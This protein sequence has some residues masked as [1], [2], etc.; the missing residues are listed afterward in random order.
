M[1]R[2]YDRLETALALLFLSATVVAVLVAAIGRSIGL[3]LT[4]APQFAQLFLLWTCMFGADLCMRHGEHIRVTA[5]P[6]LVPEKA[7]RLLSLFSTVLIL[8]F[9]VWIAWHGFHLAIGNWSRELGG[10]GLSYGIVTLA[11]PVG[12][13]LLT[14][15]TL[16]RLWSRGWGG[17]LEPDNH[18]EEYPL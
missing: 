14:I 9:L 18:A 5:L 16:R 2:L 13:V 15:S 7:R 3:P 4:S 12:A 6:D 8:V 17:V 10:A 11:L 1:W